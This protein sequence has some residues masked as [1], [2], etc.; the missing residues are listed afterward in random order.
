MK[1]RIL[2]KTTKHYDRANDAESFR[3]EDRLQYST[4]DMGDTDWKDVPIVDDHPTGKE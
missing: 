3:H 2:R 1:L 4:V